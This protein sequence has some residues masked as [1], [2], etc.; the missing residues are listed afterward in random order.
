LIRLILLSVTRMGISEYLLL[1]LRL[2]LTFINTPFTCR[3]EK[4]F[5]YYHS[6]RKVVIKSSIIQFGFVIFSAIVLNTTSNVTNNECA[7]V[8]LR[9]VTLM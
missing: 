2:I 5:S 7:G 4:R 6:T 8:V 9:H 1:G 3:T